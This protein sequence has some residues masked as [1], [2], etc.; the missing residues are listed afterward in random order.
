MSRT[1]LI[2]CFSVSSR[3]IDSSDGPSSNQAD[4]FASRASHIWRNARDAGWGARHNTAVPLPVSG[5]CGMRRHR[6]ERQSR[7]DGLCGNR[8]R[9]TPFRPS[10]VRT[11]GRP[12]LPHCGNQQM[13][14]QTYR[15]RSINSQSSRSLGP[16]K[17]NPVVT[18]TCARA[19][20]DASPLPNVSWRR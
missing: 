4:L 10:D 8:T 19:P 11:S 13:R 18:A 12:R 15:P 2:V 7:E 20:T 1:V 14:N 5:Q 16:Q 17:R 6:S 3:G 9:P